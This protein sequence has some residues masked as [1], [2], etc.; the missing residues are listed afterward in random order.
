M[1]IK[2]S[3]CQ[4]SIPMNIASTIETNNN[5][6]GST[7]STNN[8]L[9]I[10]KDL[11][12]SGLVTHLTNQSKNNSVQSLQKREPVNM[13]IP[14]TANTFNQQLKDYKMQHEKQRLLHTSISYTAKVTPNEPHKSVKARQAP[15]I[16]PSLDQQL[17]DYKTKHNK[18]CSIA[19]TKG[20]PRKCVKENPAFSNIQQSVLPSKDVNQRKHNNKMRTTHK[21]FNQPTIK[22]TNYCNQIKRKHHIPPKINHVNSTNYLP[23]SSLFRSGRH[24]PV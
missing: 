8:G 9:Q 18:Q 12:R 10:T 17:K 7:V 5:V 16:S 2:P 14:T 20:Q 24:P 3:V 4:A 13:Q 23:D 21:K 22:S 11:K 6:Q 19:T 1:K 15:K